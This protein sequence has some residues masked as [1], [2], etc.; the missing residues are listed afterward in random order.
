MVSLIPRTGGATKVGF[1]VSSEDMSLWKTGSEEAL[2][3]RLAEWCP[4]IEFESLDFGAIYP[5][6]FPSKA[7]LI[8][9]R[10]RWCSLAMPVTRCT[11]RGA[12][13]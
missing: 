2:L 13:V 1:P 9:E 5:P 11:L 8:G 3:R 4:G 12:W 10:G 7:N 6:P